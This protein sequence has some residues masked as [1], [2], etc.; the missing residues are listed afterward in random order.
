MD[1]RA[2]NSRLRDALKSASWSY[3]QTARQISLIAAAHKDASVA[4]GKATIAHW[5][6]GTVPSGQ[7]QQYLVEAL[8]RRL[9]RR[10]SPADVGLASAHAED[11]Q[12]GLEMTG[13]PMES[14]ARLGD[15][16]T[17]RR[18]ALASAVYSVSA[19]TLPLAFRQAA[20]ERSHAAAAGATIG[21]SDVQA[22][23][24]ITA[25]FVAA[26]EVYGGSH[27][28]MAAISYLTTEVA[29]FC[30]GRFASEA[31]RRSMLGAGAEL[32]YMIGFKTHDAGM[33][34]LAQRYYLQAFRLA[35][36]SDP[37]AHTAYCLRILAH[38]AFDLGHH[39]HCIHLA[40]AAID[41]A[42]GRVDQ[43]TMGLFL[44]TLAMAHATNGNS[45]SAA[46]FIN[47][48]E[49]TLSAPP[50][51]SPGWAASGGRAETRHGS[52][53]GKTLAAMGDHQA[54]IRLLKR[55]AQ[56]WSPT[57]HPRVRALTLAN[58]AESQAALG[59]IE[60]ACETWSSALDSM[61]G[62]RSA[63]TDRA[64]RTMRSHLSVYRK[65]GLRSAEE[66]DQKA[67]L[68]R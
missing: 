19:L 14:L 52:N 33:D 60:E 25:A 46:H 27:A 11:H 53:A 31:V 65:R 10:I 49:E 30:R 21:T 12:V 35:S 56:S 55:S 40:E 8:S 42:H 43:A 61:Q 67:S 23:R 16:E 54:A 44:N 28:R 17:S 58:L 6:A 66:L 1:D 47:R 9:G 7:A 5:V 38:Q 64:V 29:D 48:A 3:E 15:V 22:V 59:R 37:G 50:D 63:R 41:R 18:A 57:S 2:V 26:D 13:D 36:E 24:A 32:A 62:V 20:I 45:A 68:L 51:E 34:A 39:Q 4:P